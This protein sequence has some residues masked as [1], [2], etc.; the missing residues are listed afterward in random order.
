MPRNPDT[1]QLSPAELAAAQ[2]AQIFVEHA[3]LARHHARL[4]ATALLPDDLLRRRR[5]LK[6]QASQ[7]LH[8]L[9]DDD[10][11]EATSTANRIEIE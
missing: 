9:L 7:L 3:L 6:A 10:P 1:T 5:L 2:S 11:G 8:T 4:A